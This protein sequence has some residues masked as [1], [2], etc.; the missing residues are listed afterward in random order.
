MQNKEWIVDGL[1]HLLM[2]KYSY[3]L[4]YVI[5]FFPLG[6]FLKQKWNKRNTV[7]YSRE[8]IDPLLPL[9]NINVSCMLFYGYGI[10]GQWGR[11]ERCGVLNVDCSIVES[12]RFWLNELVLCLLS[13]AWVSVSNVCVFFINVKYII[14]HSHYIVHNYTN[15]LDQGGGKWSGVYEE[16]LWQRF[17]YI[18][19]CIF[20]TTSMNKDSEK[21]F[22]HDHD[23]N[24]KMANIIFFL[25][26]YNLL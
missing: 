17:H 3:D 1:F 11:K 22:R 12:N 7:W 21:T 5:C 13:L 25:T 19:E 24:T 16:W 2:K 18:E 20:V 4:S 10:Y 14:L 23:Y 15:M 8:L 6:V 26:H 9:C